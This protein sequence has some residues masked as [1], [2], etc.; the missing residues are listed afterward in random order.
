MA[1][2][3]KSGWIWNISGNRP[4]MVTSVV[5]MTGRNRCVAARKAASSAAWPLRLSW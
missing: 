2:D 4:A 1:P 3:P 5:S